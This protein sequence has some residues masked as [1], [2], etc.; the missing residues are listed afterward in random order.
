MATEI[1]KR[2]TREKRTSFN[3]A[4]STA[5]L[6]SIENNKEYMKTLEVSRNFA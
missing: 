4:V 3:D 5:E 6:N 2:K 1:A